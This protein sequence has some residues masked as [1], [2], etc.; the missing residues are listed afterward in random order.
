MIKIL[1]GHMTLHVKIPQKN[2]IPFSETNS[3]SQIDNVVEE[4]TFYFWNYNV[5]HFPFLIYLTKFDYIPNSSINN[6]YLF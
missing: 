2:L 5:P 1:S 6:N 3:S 4:A